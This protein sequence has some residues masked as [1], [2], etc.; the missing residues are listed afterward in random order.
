MTNT[1]LANYITD[2]PCCVCKFHTD[3]GCKKWTCVFD[4]MLTKRHKNDKEPEA[5]NDTE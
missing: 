4:E 1:E 5:S 2:R 3:D